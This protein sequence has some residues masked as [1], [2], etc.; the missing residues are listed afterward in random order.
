MPTHQQCKQPLPP[1]PDHR[2]GWLAV[3][4]ISD[5]GSLGSTRVPW[6]K[7]VRIDPDQPLVI[8]APQEEWTEF[9]TWSGVEYSLVE[10]P[11]PETRQPTVNAQKSRH[12]ERPVIGP[13]SPLHRW[14]EAARDPQHLWSILAGPDAERDAVLAEAKG[15]EERGMPTLARQAYDL[16]ASMPVEPV[17]LDA[18][19]VGMVR[20]S[21][22]ARN[23]AG[24]DLANFVFLHRAGDHGALGVMHDAIRTDAAEWLPWIWG[25]PTVNRHARKTGNGIARSRFEVRAQKPDDWGRF[26]LLGNIEIATLYSPGGEP[27]TVVFHV[28]RDR[29]TF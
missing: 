28:E 4:S 13:Y 9:T 6:I 25:H 8:D 16:A 11:C 5:D 19:P 2:L 12:G 18:Y 15:L 1:V 29:I 3:E 10:R 21:L 27:Q 24:K 22:A 7:R 23:L 20:T 17:E 26:T 14:R